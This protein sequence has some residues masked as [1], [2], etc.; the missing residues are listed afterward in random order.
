MTFQV[1]WRR[2]KVRCWVV[3]NY[4]AILTTIPSLLLVVTAIAVADRWEQH[5]DRAIAVQA[6]CLAAAV[7]WAASRACPRS[8]APQRRDER[9][10]ILILLCVAVLL[11]LVLLRWLP[12]TNQTGFEELQT[13]GIAHKMLAT[14]NLPLEF[15]FTNLFATLGF[16]LGGETVGALR[17]PFVALGVVAL[18]VLVLT[19][20]DLGVGWSAT[21][22]TCLTAATLRWLV[23]G[24]VA[25]ELFASLWIAGAIVWCL[26]RSERH[27]DQSARWAALTG[28]LSGMLMFEYTSYRVMILLSGAWFLW[29]ALQTSSGH[30]RTRVQAFVAFVVAFAAMSAPML[31]DVVHHP[32][33]TVFFEAFRR[34]GGERGEMLSPNALDHVKQYTMA[35]AGGLSSADQLL[36]PGGEPVVPPLIGLL[37]IGGAAVAAIRRRPIVRALVATAV[38]TIVTASLSANNIAIGRMFPLLPLAMVMLGVSLQDGRRLL[39]AAW[40][41]VKPGGYSNAGSSPSDWHAGHSWHRWKVEVNEPLF[42]PPRVVFAGLALTIVALNVAATQRM[43][44][45]I[46]VLLEYCNGD[47]ATAYWIGKDA[48]LGQTVV[49]VTP[50]TGQSWQTDN[51]A[52]WLYARKNVTIRGHGRWPQR[53]TIPPGVLL[54]VGVR[55]R[56]LLDEELRPLEEIAKAAG[57]SAAIR[58]HENAAKHCSVASVE[59]PSPPRKWKPLPRVLTWL[60]PAPRMPRW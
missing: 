6:V 11:R 10:A 25:D 24:T 59:L 21:I 30:R 18:A 42:D 51:D 47:Y 34:H 48:R 7:I 35:L 32:G 27:L 39:A 54:V 52:M 4:P 26:V 53:E 14:G 45:N 37:V 12:P 15:R 46:S 1:G 19:L 40:A 36:T 13:G 31:V 58:L 23:I 60:P 43:A 38:F 33:S 55:G 41:R 29:R 49:L 3:N 2:S 50:D 44:S 5:P 56:T 17:A 57:V 28:I 22:V 8:A 9:I 20:R 16:F